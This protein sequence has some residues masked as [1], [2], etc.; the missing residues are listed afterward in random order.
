MWIFLS[1]GY[2]LLAFAVF[3]FAWCIPLM[4]IL[5]SGQYLFAQLASLDQKHCI[6]GIP[7]NIIMISL[8]LQTKS[9]YMV[10]YDNIGDFGF[11]KGSRLG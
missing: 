6:G 7:L 2:F 5:S 4:G 3:S 9:A 8:A 1:P 10:S 11:G